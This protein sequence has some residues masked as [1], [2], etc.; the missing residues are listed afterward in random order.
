MGKELTKHFLCTALHSEGDTVTVPILWMRRTKHR[1]SKS[2]AQGHTGSSKKSQDS[3][4]GLGESEAGALTAQRHWLPST[5]P[6][7]C[8]LLDKT[9]MTIQ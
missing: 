2:L 5:L 3:R 4:P 8:V 9:M 6:S 1:D 7:L